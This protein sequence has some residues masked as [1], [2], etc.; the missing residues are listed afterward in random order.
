[1][2]GLICCWNSKLNLGYDFRSPFVAP[3]HDQKTREK[4]TEIEECSEGH[5]QEKSCP[6]EWQE[7][8]DQEEGDQEEGEDKP[9]KGAALGVKEKK[10]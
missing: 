3:S 7:N 2:K 5:G 6:R 4:D 1:M 9:T 8:G 10:R